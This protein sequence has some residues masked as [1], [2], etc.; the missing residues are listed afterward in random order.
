MNLDKNRYPLSLENYISKNSFP[1]SSDEKSEK[2]GEKV[3]VEAPA[4][5]VIYEVL[6]IE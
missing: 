6:A 2:K 3:E 5:K 1:R 4:G